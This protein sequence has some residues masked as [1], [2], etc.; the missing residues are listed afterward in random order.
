M[1]DAAST[2]DLRAA[3]RSAIAARAEAQRRQDQAADAL[4]RT[5]RLLSSTEAELDAY[6][7]LDDEIAEHQAST[8]RGWATRDD[9]QE[10]PAFAL[11]EALAERL[12]MRGV[13]A[14]NAAACRVAVDRMQTDLANAQ[15]TLQAADA[16]VC[17]AAQAVMLG[18]AGLMAA[19]A[20]ACQQR[21]WALQDQLSGLARLWVRQDGRMRPFPLPSHIAS[22]LRMERAPIDHNQ[23]S[24][25]MVEW[26]RWHAAL[27]NNPD[28]EFERLFWDTHWVSPIPP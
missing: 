16:K 8:V 11:P 2:G 12:R 13:M 17:A 25:R 28:A 1:P 3:L 10:V 6:V 24:E 5:E 26:N 20:L 18:L 15:T 27:C 21:A 4:H 22:V 7:D 14:Q 23:P 19:E 9:G